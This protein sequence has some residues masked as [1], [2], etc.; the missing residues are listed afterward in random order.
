MLEGVMRFLMVNDRMPTADACCALCCEVIT[1]SYVREIG[2][3]LI[4]CDRGCYNGHVKMATL[5]IEKRAQ[6]A[7]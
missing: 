6:K 4:Y 5:A 7:S 2:T 1:G 3:G